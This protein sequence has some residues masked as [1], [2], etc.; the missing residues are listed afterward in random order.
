M[1]EEITIAIKMGRVTFS[2][3]TDEKGSN[4]KTAMMAIKKIAFSH[5]SKLKSLKVEDLGKTTTDLEVMPKAQ[6][7]RVGKAET[8]LILRR[9]QDSLLPTSYFRE[10]RTTGD[11]KVELKKQTGIQF[12]SRK[13]SQ[14]LGVLFKK[15]MLSRVGS[16]GN[17]RYIAR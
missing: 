4:V 5:A 7:R 16:K 6:T 10:A 11:V 1:G 14:A 2:F 3:Q 9:L 15:S 17:F 12:T 8:S 13:V